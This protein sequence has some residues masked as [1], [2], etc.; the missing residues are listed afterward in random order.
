MLIPKC[1]H[2]FIIPEWTYIKDDFMESIWNEITSP[3]RKFFEKYIGPNTK[4]LY[5]IPIVDLGNDETLKGYCDRVNKTIRNSNLS[6]IIFPSIPFTTKCDKINFSIPNI[7][8]EKRLYS[9]IMEYLTAVFSQRI[10]RVISRH[11]DNKYPSMNS[12]RRFTNESYRATVIL[13]NVVKNSSHTK[14]THIPFYKDIV[15][16]TGNDEK[17]FRDICKGVGNSIIK[18]INNPSDID[19]NIH[20]IINLST[21]RC[22]PIVSQYANPT[23]SSIAIRRSISKTHFRSLLYRN[24]RLIY[25]K[26]G[27]YVP[28]AYLEMQIKFLEAID[29]SRPNDHWVLINGFLNYIE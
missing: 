21:N 1:E 3:Y 18:S 26:R 15:S 17:L 13:N 19:K 28:Y 5:E 27:R 14:V 10:D 22:T 4:Y 7:T 24:G 6:D 25:D 11:L 16:F 9:E 8:E 29:K 2:G 23:P 12:I 20:G